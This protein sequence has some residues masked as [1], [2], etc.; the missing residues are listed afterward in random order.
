[1]SGADGL[2]LAG[3]PLRFSAAEL[4]CRAGDGAVRR[5][6]VTIAALERA[7]KRW[8]EAQRERLDALLDRISA[9]RAAVAGIDLDRPRIMGVIN[10]TPDSFY[11]GGRYVAPAAALARAR[12]IAAAGADVIDLGPESTRPGAD[13]VAADEQCRRLLP[14]LQPLA[15]AGYVLSVD[16][17]DAVVAR[18]ALDHGARII[19][20][21]SALSADPNSVA[22]IA[23]SDAVVV[24]MHSPGGEAAP[25]AAGDAAPPEAAGE[26]DVYDSEAETRRRAGAVYGDVRLDVYDYLEARITACTARSIP[27]SRLIADPGLGFAKTAGQDAD[28]L[29]ALAL[30]H[31]LGV[32][33][34]LGASRKS[35]IAKLSDG[36]PPDDRLA[37]SL[38][39]AVMALDQGC[40]ILR[41]HDVGETAQAAAVWRAAQ[42]FG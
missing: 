19:N 6:A 12:Q 11:D 23:G 22:V 21:V 2:A 40:Q 3:G 35:F 25:E 32:P 14:V 37:G 34:L 1:M 13:E 39:A 33:L 10:L 24:L 18:A 38:A 5:Q 26:G 17:R 20:D 42:G 16:T 36:A 7:A 8:S 27:R 29:G 15:A 30:F 31:G 9:R 4:I 28:L 41:V